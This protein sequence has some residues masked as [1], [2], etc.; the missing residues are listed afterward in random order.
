MALT[1]KVSIAFIVLYCTI[2]HV[3]FCCAC[4]S[5]CVVLRKAWHGVFSGLRRRTSDSWSV[6]QSHGDDW[7]DLISCKVVKILYKV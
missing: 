3:T 4:G 1:Q 6:G 7:M 2:Y 5:L